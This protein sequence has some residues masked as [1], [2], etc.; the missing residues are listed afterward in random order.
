LRNEQ[1]YQKRNPEVAN[2]ETE[3]QMADERQVERE[4]VL[5]AA[6][7]EVWEALTDE[8]LLGEWLAEE[9]E[10]EPVPGGRASFRFEDGSEREGTVL[11][12]AEERELA[13]TWAR[14]GEPPTEVELTLEPLVAG[15]RLVVVERASAQT[16]VAISGA[17][18]GSRLAALGRAARLVLV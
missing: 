6:P 18:W 13:F 3:A 14:P 8:R 2:C 11:R 15:T 7:D 12:V 9:A 1:S 4:T 17:A 5:D 16:P 10:L